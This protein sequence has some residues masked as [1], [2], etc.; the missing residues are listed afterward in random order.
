M[1]VKFTFDARAIKKLLGKM[2]VEARKA[3]ALSVTR[4]LLA[5]LRRYPKRVYHGGD[6]PYRWQSEKQRGAGAWAVTRFLLT[7]S[8]RYSDRLSRG[9]NNPYKWQS[10]KQRK[11]YFATNGFGSGIPYKR[12]DTL[13]RGWSFRVNDAMYKRVTIY[14]PTKYGVFVMGKW[15]QSGHEEDKWQKIQRVVKD[16][17]NAALDAGQRAIDA[18]VRAYNRR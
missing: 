4:F 13:K 17:Y 18:I 9:G 5:K 12:T 15:M 14:N 16:N 11:A 8:K 3:A 10:E 2:P 1:K 6:N 7:K